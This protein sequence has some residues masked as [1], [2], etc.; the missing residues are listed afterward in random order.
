MNL[1]NYISE[2]LGIH[3]DRSDI[4]DAWIFVVVKPGFE[5]YRENIIN[6]FKKGGW[7]LSKIRTKRLLLKE[8][9]RL[10]YTHKDEKWYL[11]LCR[12]MSSAPTTAII[13]VKEGTP[14]SDSVFD[15]TGKIKDDIRK[16]W[17]ESDMRN[18]MHSSD[19]LDAMKKE[20]SIYF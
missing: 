8:A 2:S 9:K 20:S 17:S 19:S 11:S 7:S 5:K 10:Y 3:T 4:D 16:R 6:A 12:Y 1:K 18:V 15:E 13:F 14:M